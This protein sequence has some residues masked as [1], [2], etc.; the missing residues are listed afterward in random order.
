MNDLALLPPF[1]NDG[2]VHVVVE[3][4]AGSRIKFTYDQ[5]LKHFMAS[6]PLAIGIQYPYDWGFIPGTRAEDGDPLDAMVLASI[7]TYPGVVHCCQ[8]AGVIRLTQKSS[9]GRQHNDRI[10][11]IPDYQ[12]A[13]TNEGIDD[14]LDKLRRAELEHFFTNATAFESKGIRI[15]GWDGPRAAKKLIKRCI[16]AAAS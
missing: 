8:I 9:K 4:P 1:G 5:R 12:C 10:V 2:L 6:R 3:S 14:R 13:L 16:Q 15:E 7:P 11:A